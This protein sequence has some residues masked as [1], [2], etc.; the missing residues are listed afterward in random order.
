M[1]LNKLILIGNLGKDPEFKTTDAGMALCKFSI[2]TT[3]VSKGNK[4]T[5]WHNIVTFNKTAEICSKYLS[6]GSQVCIE[7]SI[8]YNEYNKDGQKSYF[9]NIIGNN[10]TLLGKPKGEKVY[11]SSSP[12]PVETETLFT[13][14]DIPF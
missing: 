1:S 5:Q 14:D 9:T 7:G 13:A 12:S 6:K 4:K 11:D 8:E 2:A 10:V 3:S